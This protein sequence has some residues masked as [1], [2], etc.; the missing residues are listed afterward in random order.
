VIDEIITW[1]LWGGVPK[2]GT[3]ASYRELIEEV[4]NP[5]G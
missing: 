5:S 1:Y 3:I 2:N 4:I